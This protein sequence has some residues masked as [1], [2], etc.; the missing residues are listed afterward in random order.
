MLPSEYS[1]TDSACWP[2]V[3]ALLVLPRR[4]PACSTL[5]ATVAARPVTVVPLS[6]ATVIEPLLIAAT[7]WPCFELFELLLLPPPAELDESADPPLLLLLSC[8]TPYA[9]PAPSTRTP[10]T[11]RAM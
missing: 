11:I 7:L 4:K 2:W 6:T 1:T 3:R 10:T 9:A 5:S 8:D